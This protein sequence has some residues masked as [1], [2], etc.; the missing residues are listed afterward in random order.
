MKALSSQAQALL[1]AARGAGDPS[2][3]TVS[4]VRDAVLARVAAGDTFDAESA[5]PPNTA[6][7]LARGSVAKFL[8]LVALAGWLGAGGPRGASAQP[9]R[10]PSLA[11][12]VRP[13]EATTAPTA[14]TV[15]APRSA[16]ESL[17]AHSGTAGAQNLSRLRLDRAARSAQSR[18]PAASAPRTT[19]VDANAPLSDAMANALRLY[20]QERWAE[21]AVQMQRVVEGDTMD[22]P[23]TVQRA[24]FHLARAL[25]HLGLHQAALDVFDEIVQRGDGHAYFGA[26]LPWLAALSREL[27]EPAGVAR[28]VGAYDLAY[29]AAFDHDDTRDLHD[30][31]LFL[32]ARARYDEAR[33]DDAIALFRRI[34]A[35]SRYYARARFFEGV[36]SVRIHRAQPAVDAFREVL[37]AAQRHAPGIE[38]PERMA[39]LAWLELA[40]LYYATS[41]YAS[42]IDAWDHIHVE[43]E[44]WL[45][46]EFEEAWAYLLTGDDPHALGNIHTLNSPYFARAFFPESLVLRGVIQFSNCQ[47]DDAES[48]VAEFHTRYDGLVPALEAYLAAHDGGDS[49]GD[50]VRDARDA[51]RRLPAPLVPLALAALGDR[52]VRRDIAY[53]DRIDAEQAILRSLPV[54]VRESSLGAR[55]FA[56]D[57]VARS[58]ALEGAADLVRQRYRRA[59]DELRDLENQATS[60]SI[61]ILGATRGELALEAQGSHLPARGAHRPQ[62]VAVDQWEEGLRW[63]FDGEYWADEI[64]TYR[65]RVTSRCT[66]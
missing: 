16:R 24:Q 60:I 2:A 58:F 55:I 45:D 47:Y 54:A 59:L 23:Q 9:V 19:T 48:A 12:N 63:P 32:Q 29:L 28:R 40:R 5:P 62:I 65:Q 46:A 41:H 30:E 4:R 11:S 25:E 39:D 36:A 27:P 56:G 10:A 14:L 49:A 53:V 20:A 21:S 31:L 6:A 33:L 15:V 44:Y 22:A 35:G 51:D 57:A 3:A 64:G 50:L 26:T 1:R 42:A 7:A 43:S 34:R 13:A 38:E 61:E 8:G 37:L 52:T 66:R 18:P 17:P